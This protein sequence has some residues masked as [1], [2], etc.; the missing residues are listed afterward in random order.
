MILIE[1]NQAG[2]DYSPC[3]YQIIEEEMILLCKGKRMG[4]Q[5][6]LLLFIYQ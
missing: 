5:T 4:K 6:P 3:S 2:K 1:I